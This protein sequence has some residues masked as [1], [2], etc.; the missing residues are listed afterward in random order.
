VVIDRN[1][2]GKNLAGCTIE[3]AVGSLLV[4]GR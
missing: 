3:L 1:A 2:F 4:L